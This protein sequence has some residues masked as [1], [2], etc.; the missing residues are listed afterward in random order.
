[1]TLEDK[2]PKTGSSVRYMKYAGLAF[3]FFAI[4]GIVFYI[5][6]EID[7]YIGNSKPI[8]AMLFILAAFIVIIYKIAKD[9]S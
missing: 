7:N 4:F 6:K 3:Q 2:N 1:M 5:G 9:L 8:F